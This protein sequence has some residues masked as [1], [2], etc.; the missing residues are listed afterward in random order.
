MPFCVSAVPIQRLRPLQAEA[1]HQPMREAF[2]RGE[3]LRFVQGAIMNTHQVKTLSNLRPE[4]VA[5][6]E[7]IPFV[8]RML[9]LPEVQDVRDSLDEVH[10][11]GAASNDEMIDVRAELRIQPDTEERMVVMPK[12]VVAA[13]L[14][15]DDDAG[16][17]N[18]LEQ[19]C[20]NGH[21]HH[22]GRRASGSEE[23]CFYE[24]MGLD[25]YGNRNLADECVSGQLAE[26]LLPSIRKNRSLMTTLSN[27]LRSRGKPATWSEVC[28]T[29]EDAIHQEGFEFALDYVAQWFL[30]VPWWNRLEPCWRDKLAALEELLC[31]SQGEAAWERAVA[32]GDIGNPLA[33]PLDIYEHGGIVYSLAGGGMQCRWDTT[34]GGAVW[35]PD[36]DAE[37]NIRYRVLRKLGVEYRPNPA[38][39]QLRKASRK[40]GL[41]AMLALTQELGLDIAPRDLLRLLAEEAQSYCQGVLDEYNAWVNGEVYGVVVYVIDRV[42]GKRIE[43]R[44]DECWGFVGSEHA[45]TSLEEAIAHEVIALGAAVH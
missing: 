38:G 28:K 18:P 6:V 7:G 25:R 10:V 42:T 4:T 44:D 31:E 9:A 3:A 15:F 40:T 29:V 30:D 32:T 17:C 41:S 35:V 33:V 12:F 24:A 5:A 14:C 19:G 39:E 43:R 36:E 20:A 22:R 21:L 16:H 11:A 27:L 34:Q 37:E 26:Q 8:T 45:E 1:T 23:A 2:P 13:G